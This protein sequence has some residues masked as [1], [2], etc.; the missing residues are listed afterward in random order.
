MLIPSQEKEQHHQLWTMSR[1]GAT[2]D[3]SRASGESFRERFGSS[4]MAR[5]CIN[6]LSKLTLTKEAVMPPLSSHLLVSS[7]LGEDHASHFTEK[8]E[9]IPLS[10]DHTLPFLSCQT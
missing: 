3:L 5:N 1:A 10:L 7:L 6:F 2:T 9:A 4:K 8:R